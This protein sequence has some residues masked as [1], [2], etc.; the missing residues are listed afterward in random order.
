MRNRDA[1]PVSTEYRL[2]SGKTA[3]VIEYAEWSLL[4]VLHARRF[5]V[6]DE[7]RKGAVADVEIV[8]LQARPVPDDLFDLA[9][10][11]ARRRLE[12]RPPAAR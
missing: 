12:A 1:R 6:R 5:A 10:A 9:D 8:S 3:S 7:L 4:P 2:G 11:T